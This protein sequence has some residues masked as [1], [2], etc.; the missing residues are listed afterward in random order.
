MHILVKNVYPSENCCLIIEF[1]NGEWKKYDCRQL[2]AEYPDYKILEN[3]DVFNL[4]KTEPG[5]FG[6]SWNEDIDLPELELWENSEPYSSPFSGLLSFAEA[7][8]RWHIDDSTLRKAVANGRLVENIDVKKFGKQ[9]VIS[10][11][12]M[13]KIFGRI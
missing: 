6:V 4:V 10:E 12:A 11:Q 7:A 13:D 3:P 8:D 9:W 5:G 2:F 1:S